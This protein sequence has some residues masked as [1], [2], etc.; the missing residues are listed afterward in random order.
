MY[1][2]LGLC[3][4]CIPRRVVK[5]DSANS[6]ALLLYTP[7]YPMVEHHFTYICAFVITSSPEWSWGGMSVIKSNMAAIAIYYTKCLCMMTP[8]FYDC[9][10]CVSV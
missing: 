3:D 9:N 7:N 6:V 5:H 8:R 10:P 4:E 1:C 2:L